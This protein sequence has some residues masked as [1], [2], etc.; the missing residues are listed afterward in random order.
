MSLWMERMA[1]GPLYSTV[2]SV[3]IQGRGGSCRGA[4]GSSEPRKNSVSPHVF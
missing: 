2:G 4:G 3:H 1:I